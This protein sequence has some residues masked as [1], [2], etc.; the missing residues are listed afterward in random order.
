[1]KALGRW[2][3]EHW[4]TI[5][6][7]M[8]LLLVLECASATGVLRAAFFPR[9]TT[10]AVHLRDLTLDGTLW[11]HTATTLARIGWSFALAA[12]LGVTAGLAMIMLA[13]L[14]ALNCRRR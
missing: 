1:M 2:L 3:A 14:P 10:I 5:G 7:P 13:I 11:G 12:V 6:S 9:P 4:I 8:A